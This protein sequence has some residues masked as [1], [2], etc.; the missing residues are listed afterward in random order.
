MH[1]DIHNDAEETATARVLLLLIIVLTWVDFT[2]VRRPVS[3]RAVQVA[4]E[5]EGLEPVAWWS[6]GASL[7]RSCQER[8][9][10]KNKY[11]VLPMIDEGNPKTKPQDK[12]HG[13][14][15]RRQQRKRTPGIK[16]VYIRESTFFAVGAA[17]REKKK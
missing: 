12:R 5:G 10:R 7:F 16:D 15:T 11:G 9:E 2:A 1:S 3:R 13:S 8:G 4:L 6:A 17:N 14:S